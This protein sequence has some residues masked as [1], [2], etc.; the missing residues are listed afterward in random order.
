MH[1]LLNHLIYINVMLTVFN[2]LPLPPLDGSRIVMGL[3]PQGLVSL[4]VK[5]EPYGF[6]IIMGLFASG[7][8][9][10]LVMPLIHSLV[11]LLGA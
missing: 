1:L 2:L 10:R 4:Y 3:L 9:N 5:I 11:Y 6:L 8:L 7:M